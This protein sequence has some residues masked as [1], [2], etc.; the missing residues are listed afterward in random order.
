MAEATMEVGPRRTPWHI[1]L[2]G[3]L[4]LLWN[5]FG[6]FDF[7]MT[8]TRGEAYWRESGMTQAMIDYYHAMPAWMYAPWFLGVWGAVLGSV[9][10]LLRRR[11]ATPVFAVSLLGAAGVLVYGLAVPPPPPPAAM[12]AMSVFP[13][14]IV[15]V[16]ALLL[17][18]AWTM[19]RRGVLR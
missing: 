7:L 15:G 4:S 19:A 5:A 10:L 1:W 18:Y 16:A 3:G 14:L 2:V 11:L 8:A 13:W 12:A 6:A 17:L 9:L